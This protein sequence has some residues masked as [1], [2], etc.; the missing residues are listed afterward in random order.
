MRYLTLPIRLTRWNAVGVELDAAH[1]KART[2]TKTA[3][4][5]LHILRI[6]VAILSIQAGHALQRFGQVYL[7]LRFADGVSINYAD[8]HR[9]VERVGR[10]ACGRDDDGRDG[11]RGRRLRVRCACG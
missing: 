6:V 5:K 3:H 9:Q 2:C 8:C 4:R 11:H 10:D 7:Q 1:T